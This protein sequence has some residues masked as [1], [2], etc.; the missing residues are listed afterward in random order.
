VTLAE[1]EPLPP[2]PAH[3]PPQGAGDPLAVPT[4]GGP[5]FRAYRG[6]ACPYCGAALHPEEM[7]A[8]PQLCLSCAGNFEGTP[9]SPPSPYVPPLAL[10]EAGPAGGTPCA[11]HATNAAVGTCERCGLFVCTLCRTEVAGQGLCPACFD[12]LRAEGGLPALRTT[13]VDLRGLALIAGFGGLFFFFLSIVT[14]PLTLVLA[15][16]A[17]RQRQRGEGSGGWVGILLAFGLGIAQIG[18]GLFLL[19]LVFKQAKT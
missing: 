19:F 10:A 17:V 1:P 9:F 2:P 4:A 7:A 16:L 8:G 14:G 12:R 15:I 13:F 18:L 6:P 5:R 3:G 11:V